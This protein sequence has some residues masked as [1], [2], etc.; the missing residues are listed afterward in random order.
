MQTDKC[1]C[2]EPGYEGVFCRVE[3]TCPSCGRKN[4]WKESDA[5]V[6]H[7]DDVLY[8]GTNKPVINKGLYERNT[9]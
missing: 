1:R 9:R 6:G 8:R 7:P 5:I 3:W 4:T 2:G